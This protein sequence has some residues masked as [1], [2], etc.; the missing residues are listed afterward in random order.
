V[1]VYVCLDKRI[2]TPPSWMSGW[3]LYSGEL[4]TSDTGNPTRRIFGKSFPAGKITLGGN[5]DN[6]MPKGRN[7]Y[8]VVIVPIYT[9]VDRWMVYR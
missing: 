3:S 5:R 1:M 8:T 2:T 6:S 4:Q 9:G 7:M